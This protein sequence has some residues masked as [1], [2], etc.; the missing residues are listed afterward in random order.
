M[1]ENAKAMDKAMRLLSSRAHSRRELGRK[2]YQRG[3]SSTAVSFAISECERL[4]LLNDEGFASDFAE[5]LRGKGYG[6]GKIRNALALKGVERGIIEQAALKTDREEEYS[7][8]EIALEKK[9]R[10][11]KNET[12]ARKR[13]EKAYRFLVSRGFSSDIASELLRKTM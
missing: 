4:G 10:T 13:K 7:R 11:L 9:L 2:L 6:A 1:D 12:D 5:E 3:F 8:A